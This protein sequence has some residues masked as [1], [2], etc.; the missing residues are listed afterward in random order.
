MPDPRPYS[1]CR[2]LILKNKIAKRK[3]R[4]RLPLNLKLNRH[5]FCYNFCMTLGTTVHRHV[6]IFCS[7]GK[8]FLV[9]F[10]C[11]NPDVQL[12]R[13]VGITITISEIKL[14]LHRDRKIDTVAITIVTKKILYWIYLDKQCCPLE[15]Y[16]KS[17]G[18]ITRRV[19]GAP[20][21]SHLY[22]YLTVV[23]HIN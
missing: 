19:H 14:D 13:I 17:C 1:K 7:N 2:R 5:R 15:D 16:S 11:F 23:Y 21:V 8:K 9:G 10:V 20:Q 12:N 3:N 6:C 18:Y 22:S 4:G